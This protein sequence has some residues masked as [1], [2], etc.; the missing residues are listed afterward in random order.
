MDPASGN[1]HAPR[2]LPGSV[3]SS[4]SSLADSLGATPPQ[5]TGNLQGSGSLLSVLSAPCAAYKQGRVH[6]AFSSSGSSDWLLWTR[7]LLLSRC[8]PVLPRYV[9]T[10][11]CRHC[12]WEGQR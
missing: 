2:S 12:C 11:V 5:V 1:G 10:N 4:T 6:G 9:S 3:M 7:Q 8:P